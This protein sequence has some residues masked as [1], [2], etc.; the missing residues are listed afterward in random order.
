[1]PEDNG[2]RTNKAPG[3]DIQASPPQPGA[4][5]RDKPADKDSS[6]AGKPTISVNGMPRRISTS[7][8]TRYPSYPRGE[9]Q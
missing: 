1:M 7:T 3:G 2:T 9:W 6:P 8:D 5:G 4:A